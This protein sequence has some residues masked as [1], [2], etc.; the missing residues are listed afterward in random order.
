MTDKPKRKNKFDDS[1]DKQFTQDILTLLYRDRS[2]CIQYYARIKGKYF[3]SGIQ[4]N[5]FDILYSFYYKYRR[6]PTQDE[7]R[8]QVVKQFWNPTQADLQLAHSTMLD[9]IYDLPLPDGRVVKDSL[10]KWIQ[11][12]EVSTL[13]FDTVENYKD[14]DVFDLKKKITDICSISLDDE[15]LGISNK[16]F[17]DVLLRMDDS[18]DRLKTT[19]TQVDK[20]F[21][22]G[23]KRG[24]LAVFMGPSN[25]GKTQV[26]IN[27]G[28]GFLIDGHNVLHLSLE[29]S[30]DIVARR[31]LCSMNNMR[32]RELEGLSKLKDIA[33]QLNEMTVY[34]D[35]NLRIKHTDANSFTVDDLE[36]YLARLKEVGFNTDVLILDYADLLKASGKHAEERHKLNEIYLALRRLGNQ[37]G[38]AVV[39]VSQ[40][41]KVGELVDHD[42]DGTV[43]YIPKPL[44]LAHVGEDWRKTHTA[45]Y[46]IGIRRPVHTDQLPEQDDTLMYLDV[47]KSR[48]AA[49]DT[50]MC[51][52]ANWAKS[53]MVEIEPGEISTD[54]L[55]TELQGKKK[56]I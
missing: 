9:E 26:L 21:G 44:S 39:T 27:M 33:K 23:M 36:S 5:L 38:I 40:T 50:E 13:I 29:M 15:D 53:L 42:T 51:F 3:T 47:L 17:L 48:N 2:F 8:N 37:L 25:R 10:T 55:V 12:A 28:R 4:K 49:R 34:T 6:L 24:E 20:A 30:E 16:S 19:F 14:L 18:D 52:N 46:I 7:A 31:Y 56:V 11:M 32:M 54:N 43:S 35:K 22:G 45:D 41:N 1:F